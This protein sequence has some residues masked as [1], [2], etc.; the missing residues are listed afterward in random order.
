M[1][2]QAPEATQARSTSTIC[3]PPSSWS[4]QFHSL[5]SRLLVEVSRVSMFWFLLVQNPLDW[6]LLFH[7]R[8]R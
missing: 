8:V 7:P 4:V 2:A 3:S 6:L 5:V 1:I